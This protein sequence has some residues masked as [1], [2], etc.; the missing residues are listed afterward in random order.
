V[1][2]AGFPVSG[3]NFDPLLGGLVGSLQM[4]EK[5]GPGGEEHRQVHDGS[6]PAESRTR[7]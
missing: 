3:F 2:G 1:L 6:L 5:G 4:V 7:S